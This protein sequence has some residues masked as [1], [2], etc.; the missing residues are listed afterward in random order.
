MDDERRILTAVDLSH[1]GVELLDEPWVPRG[2]PAVRSTALQLTDVPAAPVGGPGW[3][4]ERPGFAWG[5]LG[6]AACWLGG[7]V[8][9]VRRMRRASLD[10]EPDQIGLALL[11]QADTHLTA[12]AAVLTE[13][14]TAVDAG[15]VD[16][17]HAWARCVRVRHVVHDAC[18]AVLG[19]A[20]HALGPGPLAGEEDH[21]ARV[22]D[23]QLYLRQH[24]AERDA[25]LVGRAVVDGMPVAWS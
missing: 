20:A 24:K 10:R 7:A 16:G 21:A 2:L 17:P 6:V 12:A 25:A 3:Y 22:A 1:P 19:L 23:L 18:E 13:A 15:L 14:A 8:G 5:G 11:G 9:L 4:L